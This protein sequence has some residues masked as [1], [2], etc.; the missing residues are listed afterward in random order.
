MD[1]V[2]QRSET[3]RHGWTEQAMPEQP[4]TAFFLFAL[5][6]SARVFGISEDMLVCARICFANQW[7]GSTHHWRWEA[8]G[9]AL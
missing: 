4:V 5:C 6:L 3:H 7:D 9:L 1:V 8:I 2:G